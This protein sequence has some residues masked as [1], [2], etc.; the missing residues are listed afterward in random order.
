MLFKQANLSKKIFSDDIEQQ[1][2][3]N[4]YGEGL[5]AAG[6]ADTNVVALSADLTESTRA[7]AFAEKFPER[8]FEVRQDRF[9]ILLRNFFSRS[10]LGADSHH[11]FL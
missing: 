11:H 3:R 5:L 10:Q 1:P 6:E 4:G 9:H 7:E 8:F 2:T